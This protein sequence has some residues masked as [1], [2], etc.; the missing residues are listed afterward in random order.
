MIIDD[1]LIDVRGKAH[2]ADTSCTFR[3]VS[4]TIRVIAM[5]QKKTVRSFR[6]EKW[7]MPDVRWLVSANASE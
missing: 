6:I 5:V 4:S 3:T 2:N 7:L 1:I